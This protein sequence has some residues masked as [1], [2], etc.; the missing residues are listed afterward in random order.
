MN[1]QRRRKIILGSGAVALLAVVMMAGPVADI[2]VTH[3]ATSRSISTVEAKLD[4]GLIAFSFLHC[5]RR[6]LR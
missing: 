3:D 4:L 5:S 2:R 1:G 6:A